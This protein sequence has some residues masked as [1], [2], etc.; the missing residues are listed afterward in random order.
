EEAAQQLGL[1]P[2]SLHGRLERARGLLRQ[3]LTNRGLTLAAVLS[4]AALGESVAQAALAPTFVVSSTR[5]ALLLAAGQPLT[6]SVV[7][8]PVLALTQ[9]VLKAMFRTKVKLGTAAVLC[10]GLFVALIGGSLTSLGIAQ[11]AK[12][13]PGIVHRDSPAAKAESD[14]DF[15]RRISKD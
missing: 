11:D 3:R 7:T 4:A 5:A 10:A 14:A 2:G 13:G 1:S 15:I 8:T 9:E 12:P 6:D